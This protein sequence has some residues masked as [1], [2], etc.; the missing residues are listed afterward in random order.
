MNSLLSDLY[1]ENML[2]QRRPTPPDSELKGAGDITLE[3]II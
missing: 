1:N 3:F 2:N